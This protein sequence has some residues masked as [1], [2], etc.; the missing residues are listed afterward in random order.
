MI[1][2]HGLVS[3]HLILLEVYNEL[4]FG[5]IT[6]AESTV[7]RIRFCANGFKTLDSDKGVNKSGDVYVYMAFAEAPLVNSN[8][9]PGN[10]R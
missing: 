1:S 3:A 2:G 10:A 4:L 9:V 8:G 6:Q 5:D 7:D